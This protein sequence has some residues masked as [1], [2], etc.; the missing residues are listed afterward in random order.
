MTQP[1]TIAEATTLRDERKAEFSELIEKMFASSPDE[2]LASGLPDRIEDAHEAANAAQS[3][4]DA[5]RERDDLIAEAA[6]AHEQYPQFAGYWDGWELSLITETIRTK[7]GLSFEKG[8]RVLV[9]PG[10]RTDPFNG[11]LIRYRTAY[12][13]RTRMNTS[14]PAHNV[15]TL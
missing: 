1:T 2:I 3:L 8:D 11:Q 4:L 14:L 5:L 15:I 13:P 10:L 9:E 12:S 7:A 6:A